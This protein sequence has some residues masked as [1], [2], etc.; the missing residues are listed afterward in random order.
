MKLGE[1]RAELKSA[2]AEHW[3]RVPCAHLVDYGRRLSA[4]GVVNNDGHALFR[5]RQWKFEAGDRSLENG[6]FIG[7]KGEMVTISYY[8]RLWLTNGY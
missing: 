8:G 1:K 2:S 7:H 6:G 4:S 3:L 5:F